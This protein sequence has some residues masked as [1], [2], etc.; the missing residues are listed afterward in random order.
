VNKDVIKD[1]SLTV[2]M[3]MAMKIIELLSAIMV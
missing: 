1:V 2:I 3:L